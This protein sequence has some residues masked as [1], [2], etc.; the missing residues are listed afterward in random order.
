M[1]SIRRFVAVVEFAV[2]AGDA[3]KL[4]VVAFV[5]VVDDALP[6]VVAE[7]SVVVEGKEGEN[8]DVA[9]D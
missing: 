2:A 9:G 5:R 1:S 6:V 4:P 7:D 3:G 8:T